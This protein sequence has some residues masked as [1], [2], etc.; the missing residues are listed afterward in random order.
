[1]DADATPIEVSV[2]IP[3]YNHASMLRACLASLC[4]QTQP[5]NDF[6][7]IVVIDGSTDDTRQ[8]LTNLTTPFRLRTCWQDNSGQ[9]AALNR[10]IDAAIGRYCVILDD[11]MIADPALIAA[12]LRV[13]REHNGVI[14]LGQITCDLPGH[15][16]GFARYLAEWWRGHYSRLNSG[17]RLPSF[18]DCFSGNLSA[19]RA[20]LRAIGGFAP[21][22]TR[23]FDIELGYRLVQFGLPA[24]YIRD[25]IGHQ[26]YQKNF[27]AI[28]RDAK[29]EGASEVD[30]YRRNPAMLP[31]L[32]LAAFNATSP[33]AVLLRRLL[34]ALHVPIRP[35]AVVGPLLRRRHWEGEWYRF[36]YDLCYW[37]GVHRAVPD[38]DTWQRLTRGTRI[39]MYH[40]FGHPG[41]PP[42]R[43]VVPGR[44]F[45]RQM[46]W[47]R[48]RGYRVLRLEDFLRDRR[49]YELPPAR[50]L[51]ITMDDGYADNHA[52]AY[53][54]LRRHRFPATIFLVSGAIGAANRWDEGSVLSGRPLASCR[55]IEEMR[56][57]GISYGAHTRTHPPLTAIEAGRAREEIEGSRADLEDRLGQ[58]IAA[59]SYPYGKYDAT[60]EEV[61][62]ERGFAGA[63]TVRE[64]PN[65]PATSPWALRRIEIY[66]TDSLAYFI[67]ALFLGRAPRLLRRRHRPSLPDELTPMR[68]APG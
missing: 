42:S 16:D 40:A 12:H 36:L 11:D 6:E 45:A 61:V 7:V 64:G 49:A 17:Q 26:D 9:C 15:A 33:R 24:I 30:L 21:D 37:R 2:I 48:W 19:P 50:S 28:T 52:V 13:Q 32:R 39:L 60:I 25:A 14:G 8:M 47:L 66:G 3:T 55:A 58:P 59:F 38:R 46:A 1:M 63:C 43:Y 34:L 5:P 67:L 53:P 31:G 4:H 20:A 44:R 29:N 35:L 56:S 41:E 22:L 27:P 23:N 62:K 57:G 18:K 10:G 54:I 51:V 65:D 68:S